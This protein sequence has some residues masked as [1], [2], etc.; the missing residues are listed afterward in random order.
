MKFRFNLPVNLIFGY[1]RINE[2][3]SIVS[4]YGKRALVVTGGS[5]DTCN[6]GEKY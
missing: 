1:G 2:A 4:R 5:I 3:G 6:Y